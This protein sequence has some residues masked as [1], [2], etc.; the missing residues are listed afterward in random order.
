MHCFVPSFLSHTYN[1]VHR[2]PF[3]SIVGVGR[4]IGARNEAVA[5][6]MTWPCEYDEFDYGY[7]NSNGISS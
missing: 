1:G 4:N 2:E 5:P 3:T 6:L 7:G